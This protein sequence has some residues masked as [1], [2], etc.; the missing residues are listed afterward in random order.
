MDGTTVPES[1]KQVSVEHTRGR[2]VDMIFVCRKLYLGVSTRAPKQRPRGSPERKTVWIR[3]PHIHA[4]ER[5]MQ[6][7][8]GLKLIKG[9]SDAP[10]RGV[11]PTLA[12]VACAGSIGA[13]N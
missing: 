11:L 10:L 8:Y 12:A 13:G 3:F 2:G 4:R 7:K 9:E 5:C 1:R 6:T